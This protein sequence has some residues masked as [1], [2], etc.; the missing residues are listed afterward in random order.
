MI[1]YKLKLTPKLTCPLLGDR[2]FGRKAGVTMQAKDL[3]KAIDRGIDAREPQHWPLYNGG[4]LDRSEYVTASEVG[5]CSRK[6]KLDKLA[7]KR[8]GYTPGAGTK[9]KSTD[10]WGFWER[11]HNVERW[12]VEL[13]HAGWEGLGPQTAGWEIMFT[14]D[15]QVS[16]VD[17]VQ[18]GTPD[19][20]AVNW[21]QETFYT[22]EFK[23]HDPRTNVSRLP[24][25]VHRDQVVQNTDLIATN[26]DLSPSG[27]LILYVDASDHKRRYPFMIDWN[28]E[29]ADRLQAKAERIMEASPEEL[30]PE[31]MFS[32]NDDCKHCKHTVACNQ[33]QMALKGTSHDKLSEAASGLFG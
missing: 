8:D 16:F 18:S 9:T 24:K 33:I 11:G 25:I 22:L 10:D 27:G 28:E 32:P 6:I 2:L 23:S 19:G 5:T 3:V 1:Y 21:A 7:M 26:M 31:G 17:G 20:I 4:I 15:D 29:H 30:K 13:L 12:L 14:G